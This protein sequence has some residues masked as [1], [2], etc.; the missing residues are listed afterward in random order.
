[1]FECFNFCFHH[2]G[3]NDARYESMSCCAAFFAAVI[4]IVGTAMAV[5]FFISME[6]IISVS[7]GIVVGVL[8]RGL[9]LDVLLNPQFLR[10]SKPLAVSI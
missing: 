2:Q 3:S 8:L 7:I 5:S 4:I 1:M 9:Y 6:I 10:R